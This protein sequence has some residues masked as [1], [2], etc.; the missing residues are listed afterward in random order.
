MAIGR[1]PSFQGGHSKE[2]RSKILGITTLTKQIAGQ[3]FPRSAANQERLILG[4]LGR[5]G[6]AGFVRRDDGPR[7]RPQPFAAF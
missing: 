2:K 1:K 5:C 4:P 3:R 6:F 7:W